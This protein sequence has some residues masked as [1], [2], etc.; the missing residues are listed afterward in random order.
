MD[1]VLNIP[2]PEIGRASAPVAR[3]LEKPLSGGAVSVPDATALFGTQGEDR[4][5]LFRAAHSLRL[6][7]KGDRASFVVCRNINFTNVCYMGCQFCGFAKRKEEAGAETLPLDE[8]V[9]RTQEAQARGGTEVCIQGGLNPNLPWT[10][11]PDIL[12]AIKAACPDIHI[13]AFSPFE[14]WYG[15]RQAKMWA[16]PTW[17]ALAVDEQHCNARC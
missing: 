10:H 9:R 7:T 17:C 5:A 6:Q 8:I 13:H 1:G 15:A 12:K 11:Y 2:D 3:I 4:E 16:W 14:V